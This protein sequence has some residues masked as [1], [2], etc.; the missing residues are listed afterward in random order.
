MKVD[1]FFK[2]LPAVILLL[3]SCIQ[4]EKNPKKAPEINPDSFNEKKI[5]DTI[6]TFV[7]DDFP[8]SDEM[9]SHQNNLDL[10]LK[11]RS[12]KT[13][14]FDKAW[15]GNKKLKQ[16]LV[17]EMYTDFH[18]LVIFQCYTE[19]IPPDLLDRM[20]L[21][22]KDGEI[23]SNKQKLKDIKGF[24][25]HSEEID[26]K[27]FTSKKRIQLGLSKQKILEIYGKPDQMTIRN[28]I[29]KAEWKFEG[30]ILYDQIKPLNNKPIAKDSFGHQVVMY[31]K[32]EKLIAQ[33]L[34]NEIP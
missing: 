8:I 18:R 33:I 20:E 9:I 2:L 5:I 19:D 11:K 26:P 10:Q 4:S 1:E 12:G 7:V 13:Y 22:T 27:Y 17:V 24:L 3:F 23:A 28:G 15:F 30:D 16:N 29:E 34:F 6:K 14:S 21:H 31:F 25:V 32:N